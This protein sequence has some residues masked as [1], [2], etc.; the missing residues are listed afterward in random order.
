MAHDDAD[1]DSTHKNDVYTAAVAGS[2]VP[3]PLLMYHVESM[4]GLINSWNGTSLGIKIRGYE[5]KTPL[6]QRL[7]DLVNS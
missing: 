7:T 6:R 1:D 4:L 5:F 3:C 2:S